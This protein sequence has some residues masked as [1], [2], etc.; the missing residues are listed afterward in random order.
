MAYFDSIKNRA[1]WDKE[2]TKLRPERARRE[3][4][5]FPSVHQQQAAVKKVETPHRKQI[6]LEQLQ[7]AM[8]EKHGGAKAKE[9]SAEVKRVPRPTKQKELE[10]AVRVP[11]PKRPVGMV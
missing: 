6:N 2:L 8:R 10:G 9:A 11:R 1:I 5:G 7:E 3:E 4:M